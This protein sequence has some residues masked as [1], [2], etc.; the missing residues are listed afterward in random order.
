MSI[1]IT[2]L[3][4][5][6]YL[7]PPH[8]PEGWI[9]WLVFLL[10]SLFLFYHWR[11]YQRSWKRTQWI[12]LVLLALL[13][14]LAT[15]F[16]ALRLPEGGALPFPGKP[17]EPTG[18]AL[19]IFAAVPSFLAAGL[20]G[21]WPAALL[22]LVSGLLLSLGDTHTAFTPLEMALLALL[23]SAMTNQRYRTLGFRILSHPFAAA[24]LL[25]LVYPLIYLVDTLFIAGGSL[26]NRLDYAISHALL[27]WLASG[28]E[29]LVAGLFA[30]AICITLPAA[31][32]SKS[33]LEPSPSERRLGTRFF[34]YLTPLALFLLSCLIAADWI[35]AGNAARQ[36]LRE[37]MQTTA[38]VASETVPYFLETGQSLIQQL[39]EDQRLY[40]SPPN[41]L[42][43]ILSEDLRLVP[44]FRQLYYLDAAGT[45]IAGY[46]K[47][48]YNVTH[49]P[50]DE[51]VGIMLLLN[52]GPP[53]QDYTIPPEEGGTTAQVS[54]MSV[55]VNGSGAIQG[56]LLGRSDL[57]S[58]PFTQPVLAGI[59]N[60]AGE[61]GEGF[62]LDDKNNI[63]YSTSGT[64]LM[65]TYTG[66]I[67]DQPLFYDNTGADGTRLLV[68]DQPVIGHP[69]SVVLS[70]PARRVQ[71]IALDIAA[72]LLGVV[73]VLFALAVILVLFGLRLV[74]TS[75]KTLG[76]EANRISSGQLDHPLPQG[77]ED[78]I[79]QLTRAFDQMRVSLKSR[80]DELNRLLV[81]SQGVASSLEI[82]EAVKPVLESALLSGACSARVVLSATGLPEIE[83]ES[84]IPLRIGLGPAGDDYSNLD[85]AVLQL[86]AQQERLI[87]TNFTRIRALNIAAG[88]RRPESLLA[89][90]LR[91]ENLYYGTLWIAFDQPHQFSDDEVRFMVTLAGQ[92]ALAASNSRL[93]QSAEIGPSAWRPSWLP[94]PI[95]C[96]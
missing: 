86:N 89:M 74:T 9:G 65:E 8:G 57:A 44:F 55:V 84:S 53:Y 41:E 77:G 72:P 67:S 73:L 93:F 63:L 37:R 80:L 50:P 76:I 79:G 60:I 14:P 6:L 43:Q 4:R 69:W 75:L 59:K 28:G 78:E 95:R 94:L 23:F 83:N 34:F 54:F 58:N 56:L 31:W 85:E 15:L 87:L 52:G 25:A 38:Q 7:E 62:L 11:G 40:G 39:A 64:H 61:D 16:L 96:W 71:Q 22:G 35:V 91:Y 24:L 26:A 68:Y 2:L 21:P 36:M 33:P 19:V 12:T 46:P 30:E 66:R 42:N 10:V 29:L 47:N 32:G 92:A 20:L 5:T 45:P 13:V 88:L 90:A 17:V 49:P 51:Q 3:S 70:A 27:A 18:P 48:N 82:E 81:V 1:E